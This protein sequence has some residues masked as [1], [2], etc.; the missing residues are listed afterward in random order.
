MKNYN[1]WRWRSGA[2]FGLNWMIIIL[3]IKTPTDKVKVIITQ[4]K[5]FKKIKIAINL[6][7]LKVAT[8]TQLPNNL[9]PFPLPQN[10]PSF[11][12]ACMTKELKNKKQFRGLRRAHIAPAS[13]FTIS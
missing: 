6:S 7:I 3:F 13:L 9:K 1:R 5:E 4:E 12:I 8:L 2:T 11:L 10:S